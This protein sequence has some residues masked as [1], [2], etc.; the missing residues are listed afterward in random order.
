M[1]KILLILLCL[2][3][4]GFAQL[5][6]VPD[7][8][9]EQALINLGYDNILDDYVITANIDTI[10]S[11][12]V[13]NQNIYD[14]TGIEDFIN[15]D[16]LH[17]GNNQLTTLDIS[18][19]TALTYLKCLANGLT[20]LDVSNN[21]ALTFLDCR[22]N[23]LTS[24]DVSQNTAL[25]YLSCSVNQFTSLDI[26]QNIALTDLWCYDNLNLYCINVADSIWAT[27]NLTASIFSSWM[28]FSENCPISGCTDTTACNY[29]ANAT[30]N[31]NSCVFPP[32]TQISQFGSDLQ[33]NASGGNL[34]FTYLWNTGAASQSITLTTNGWYWCV[35][36]DINSCIS[37]TAFFEVINI[38]SAVTELVNSD[39]KLIKIVDVLGRN[40][41]YKK[42]TPLFY[43]YN[44]GTVEKR[45]VIE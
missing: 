35:I 20:S 17:C 26:S 37:D 24:L 39:R 42:N 34:P 19:N 27:A 31:D 15:L 2:P 22:I 25:T 38:I 14:L 23:N 13:N 32:I 21:T 12:N 18:Q 3:M 7:D 16:F 11:L 1:K 9:F 30:I 29:N 44:D 41:P 10:T 28:Y 43:N 36:V 5:T 8:T 4:I 33:I 45:I 6:Y 40:T